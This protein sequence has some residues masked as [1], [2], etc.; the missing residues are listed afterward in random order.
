MTPAPPLIDL[1]KVDTEIT[2]K[3]LR[4][5]T[6]E[7]RRAIYTDTVYAVAQNTEFQ[8]VIFIG[9]LHRADGVL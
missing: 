6:L 8:L 5:G 7:Y 1:P 3:A 2:I 4:R 9:K